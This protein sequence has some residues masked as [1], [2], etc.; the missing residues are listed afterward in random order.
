MNQDTRNLI[1]FGAVA[2]ILLFA[3]QIFILGPRQKQIQAQQAAASAAS[4]LAPTASGP[5][6]L[7]RAQGLAQSPRVVIDT[8][9]LEGSI[10]LTGANFD[11]LFLKQYKTEIGKDGIPVEVLRPRGAR[12]AYFASLGWIGAN[13][14][15]LP[16]DSSVWTVTS[17]HVLTPATPVTL[18]YAAPGLTFTRTIAVDDKYMFTVSDSV[19]NTGA[20][21][22]ALTP[23]GSVQRQDVPPLLGKNNIVHEGAIG[24]IG[25]TLQEEKYGK[26]KK[27]GSKDF[28]TG[29]GWF[30][31]TDKYWMTVL[32]PPAGQGL[33]ANTRVT[34]VSGVDIYSASYTA[35]QPLT[36]A[37]GKSVTQ[38]TRVFAGAKT[39]PVLN[40][41]QKSLGVTHMDDAIDWGHLFFLTKPMFF[42]LDWFQHHIT[43][44]GG[45]DP[46]TGA[47]VGNVGIAIL[48]LTICIRVITFPLALPGYEM[49][50]KMR[51]IQPIQKELQAKYKDDPQQL[52][53]ETMALYGKEKINPITGCLPSLLPIPIFYS[54]TKLFT[55]T[56]L[57][58][59]APFFGW[60]HDLSARDPTSIVNLFGLIPWNPATTPLI[61]PFLDGPLHI[62]AW[63]LAY[64]LVTWMSMSMTPTAGVDPTQAQIMKL[65]PVFFTFILAQYTVGLLIYWTFSGIFTI[66]QQYVLMRRYKSPNPI[67]NLIARLQ[68][69]A[70]AAI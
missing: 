12:Y 16:T 7:T 18:S 38:V 19:A 6:Y 34:P 2:L 21:P 32:I 58:W 31:V 15:G 10:A 33:R 4:A 20:A 23:Y 42:L 69:K 3:Y 62:G 36:V 25:G 67:D 1:S 47:K 14:P 51:K 37:P 53:K 56:I 68:G 52:Q 48:L 44:G 50:V 64:G 29:P 66:V 65:M 27:D 26:W 57:I 55:V 45:I 9:T 40:G 22:V 24:V 41:Y 30:G 60:I 49:G 70:P 39:L 59:H 17:G 46:T 28:D 13:L 35:A 5:T 54:L 43:F 61:G 63:P 11:D 8:P